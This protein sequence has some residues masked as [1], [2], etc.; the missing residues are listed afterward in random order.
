VCVLKKK[1]GEGLI[2]ICFCEHCE[3]EECDIVLLGFFAGSC[4]PWKLLLAGWF[5]QYAN[6]LAGCCLA[7]WITQYKR[8]SGKVISNEPRW[9][10][11]YSITPYLLLIQARVRRSSI[12]LHSIL[13]NNKEE[14]HGYLDRQFSFI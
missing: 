1:V 4:L 13:K 11:S 7:I 9:C 6:F 2:F 10:R 8:Y 14:R 3:R 12:L 5:L